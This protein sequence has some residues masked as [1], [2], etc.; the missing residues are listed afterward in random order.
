[1]SA[2]DLDLSRLGARD[3]L[4]R[5]CV[6][7]SAMMALVVA[8]VLAPQVI[9]HAGMMIPERYAACSLAP[10]SVGGATSP[11]PA[12]TCACPT[13]P[14]SVRSR[15]AF[16]R[17]LKLE[18]AQGLSGFCMRGHGQAGLCELSARLP[19]IT[20]RAAQALALDRIDRTGAGS[21]S[22]PSSS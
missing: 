19:S 10:C 4:R 14:V 13:W 1:M 11:T 6:H 22:S 21:A 17:H 7:S 9:S 8:L 15:N 16:D 20:Q 2:I 5:V 12:L 18:D 3:C